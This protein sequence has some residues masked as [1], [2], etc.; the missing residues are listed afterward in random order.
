MKHYEDE[1]TKLTPMQALGILAI[2]IA[3]SIAIAFVCAYLICV[4][5]NVKFNIK[6]G[7]TLYVVLLAIKHV[8][9]A[10]SKS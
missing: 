9:G 8:A 1:D 6:Y 10:K 5:F 2:D 3:F 4:C 7:F